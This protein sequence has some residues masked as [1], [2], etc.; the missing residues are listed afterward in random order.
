[1]G[2]SMIGHLKDLLA[3]HAWADAVFFHV[4]GGSEVREDED[5]RTR[6]DHVVQTQGYFLKVLKGNM[7]T[8][9]ER[10]VPDF[11]TLK[12]TCRANHDVFS[13]LARGLDDEALAQTV[14]I[15]WFPDPPCIITVA[16]ALMQVCLHTQH[17]RGQNMTRLKSLG[18]KPKNVDYIIW[19]WKKKPEGRW[20]Q[21]S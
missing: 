14:H 13:A 17:H 16:D 10:Q 4:W 21:G 5:L 1:M 19:L 20:E 9:E 6:M 12:T 8:L 11:E 7:V 18:V 15:P 3:H 2:G